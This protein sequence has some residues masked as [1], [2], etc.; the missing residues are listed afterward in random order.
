MGE[1]R[2][3]FFIFFSGFQKVIA[4]PGLHGRL[5]RYDWFFKS[6]RGRVMRR[7]MII[8]VLGLALNG[9]GMDSQ[10]GLF[11]AAK[12]GDVAGIAK[13]VEK[14]A[15]VNAI[16][17]EGRSPLFIAVSENQAGDVIEVL[18]DAGADVDFTDDLGRT[19]IFAAARF[20]RDPEVMAHLMAAGSDIYVTDEDGY[21]LLHA[22][23]SSNPSLD[24]LDLLI[25]SGM[26]ME[27][28]TSSGLT[29][30]LCAAK[31]GRSPAV[32]T[33]LLEGGADT[34]VKTDDGETFWDLLLQNETLKSMGGMFK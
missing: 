32:I 11:K 6:R 1:S 34:S 3:Y 23:A 13:M 9:C 31:Y 4:M 17:G 18:L 21:T 29:P 2:R 12:N 24:V 20:N 30:L 26:D 7:I 5:A 16:D 14:G 22:A 33:R 25:E 27:A 28:R 10:Q 15:D 8:M 19:P